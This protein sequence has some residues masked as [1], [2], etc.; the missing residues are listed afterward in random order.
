MSLFE[1]PPDLSSARHSQIKNQG[2]GYTQAIELRTLYENGAGKCR[3]DECGVVGKHTDNLTLKKYDYAALCGKWFRYSIN[4]FWVVNYLDY[5]RWA[6][7]A[8]DFENY[9]LIN[10]WY[11]GMCCYTNTFYDSFLQLLNSRRIFYD[12]LWQM[13]L[14]IWLYLHV[15]FMQKGAAPGSYLIHNK[16][17][18]HFIIEGLNVFSNSCG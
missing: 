6:R 18:M 9:M 14:V 10:L 17:V 11:F 16:T 13:C 4:G 7:T 1:T 2:H 5:T 15:G 8:T 3:V 12:V